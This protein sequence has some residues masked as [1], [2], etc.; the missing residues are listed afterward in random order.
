MTFRMMTLPQLLIGLLT[1]VTS[2]VE[3]TKLVPDA[4]D[5]KSVVLNVLHVV[6]GMIPVFERLM[7]NSANWPATNAALLIGLSPEAMAAALAKPSTF[8]LSGTGA[9]QQG[10]VS[11][12]TKQDPVVVQFASPKATFAP[13]LV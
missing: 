8:A 6:V 3:E 7:P 1:I 5:S 13:P 11:L 9:C 10:A 4:R 2:F 12:L